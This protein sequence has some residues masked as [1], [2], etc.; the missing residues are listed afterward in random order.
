MF[1]WATTSLKCP[2]CGA[3]ITLEE[4]AEMPSLYCPTCSVALRIVLKATWAYMLISGV[5]AWVAAYLQGLQCIIF[6]GG[7]LIYW[8]VAVVT[9]YCLSWRGMLPE[10][11]VVADSS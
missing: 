3:E 1:S 10:T 9:V 4:V 5:L 6:A 7:V 11:L 8:A 2:A